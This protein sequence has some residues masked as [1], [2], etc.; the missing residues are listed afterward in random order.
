MLLEHICQEVGTSRRIIA[1][2]QRNAAQAKKQLR[3]A[4]DTVIQTAGD[5]FSQFRQLLLGP[6][7]GICPVLPEYPCLLYTS[8]CV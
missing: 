8:R 1:T 6:Q 4:A 7:D 5:A 3:G 2:Q